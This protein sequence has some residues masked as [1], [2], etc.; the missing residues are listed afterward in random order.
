MRD[1]LYNS[2]QAA[3]LPADVYCGDGESDPMTEGVYTG[4]AVDTKGECRK[5][6][7]V[8]SVGATSTLTMQLIIQESADNSTFSTLQ[9]WD[10]ATATK[11]YDLTPTKRYIRAYA[12][13]SATGALVSHTYVGASAMGIFYNE[14]YYPNNAS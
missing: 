7:V 2:T 6:L 14:R 3:L 10:A 1:L 8:V 5:L 12:V 4:T 9:E 13:L 11:V